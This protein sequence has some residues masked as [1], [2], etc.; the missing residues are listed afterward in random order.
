M[1][2]LKIMFIGGLV[3]CDV[4]LCLV[5]LWVGVD[6]EGVLGLRYVVGRLV[7]VDLDVDFEVF[8]VVVEGVCIYVGYFGWIIG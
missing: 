4:V 7:M 2:K 8:V 1:V 3:K 6:L 5:V